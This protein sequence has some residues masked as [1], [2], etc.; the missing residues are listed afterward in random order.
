MAT[1]NGFGAATGDV[2]SISF[3]LPHEHVFD[4]GEWNIVDTGPEPAAGYDPMSDEDTDELVFFTEQTQ[5]CYPEDTLEASIAGAEVGVRVHALPPPG[6]AQV[7]AWPIVSFY[8]TREN[9]ERFLE[10]WDG[11]GPAIRDD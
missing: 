9:L 8:G 10:T 4:D 11:E 7:G 5:W 3:A 1:C 6:L 2:C